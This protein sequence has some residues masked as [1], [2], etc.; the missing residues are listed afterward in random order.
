M[1]H[2]A[3]LHSSDRIY[4]MSRLGKGVK[5]PQCIFWPLDFMIWTKNCHQEFCN[6]LCV[7]LYPPLCQTTGG[8]HQLFD[9]LF[10]NKPISSSPLSHNESSDPNSKF[11]RYKPLEDEGKVVHSLLSL[12]KEK[13][14]SI[15]LH[16]LFL[17]LLGW[18][19][20]K[21]RQNSCDPLK[22]FVT[23]KSNKSTF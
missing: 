5:D 2:H 16:V 13:T 23:G 3:Y 22:D 19:H 18:M 11:L 8:F 7:S 15:F 6:H 1:L 14:F 4:M 17:Q 20:R 10:I 21:F 9:I 12:G